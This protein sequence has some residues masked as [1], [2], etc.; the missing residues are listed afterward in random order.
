MPW[1]VPVVEFQCLLI[2]MLPARVYSWSHHAS[3]NR[4]CGF[5]QLL[6]QVSEDMGERGGRLQN[7]GLK[8]WL[9]WPLIS[10]TLK[11]PTLL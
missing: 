3:W 6:T 5:A 10:E 2:Q 4:L 1:H 11:L 8:K 9:Q 7:A